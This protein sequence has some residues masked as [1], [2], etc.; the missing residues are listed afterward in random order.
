M[1]LKSCI[2]IGYFIFSQFYFFAN[3]IK[4]RRYSKHNGMYHLTFQSSIVP[5]FEEKLA[6]TLYNLRRSLEYGRA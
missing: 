4:N 3:L 2:P 1:L 6:P 5:V